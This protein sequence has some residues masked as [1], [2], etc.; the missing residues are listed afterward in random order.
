MDKIMIIFQ[1]PDDIKKLLVNGKITVSVYGMGRIGLAIAATWIRAGAKVIGVDILPEKIN[2]LNSGKISYPE[3]KTV[4]EVLNKASKNGRLIGLLDGVKAS[5]L[6][7]VKIVIVPTYASDKG[8]DLKALRDSLLSIGRGLKRGDLVIIESTVPPG[9]TKNFALPIL[10]KESKLK[11]EEDFGLAYSPERVMVGR[12][13]KD[14][15]ESYPK[16]VAGIGERSG[17]A[18]EALYSVIARKGVIRLSSTTA[19]E[20]SKVFEGIYRDLNI[21][22]ANELA[23]LCKALGIDFMEVRKASNS[24]PYCHLHVPG[25]GVGGL[26]IPVYPYFA[27]NVGR[28]KNVNLNLVSMARKINE[29]M[30]NYAIT[31]ALNALKELPLKKVKV[32]VLGLAFRG[33]IAD[34]RLSPSYS[35]VEKLL[36]LSFEV[37]VHDPLILKDETL[38]KLGVALVSDF[39]EAVKGR[40]LIFLAT[41]HSYY[42]REGVTQIA[43]LASKPLVFI[44]GRNLFVEDSIPKGVYYISISGRVVKNV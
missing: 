5:K 34:A 26:C 15:E 9:T 13:L 24:Q 28:Q 25:I 35:L 16:I 44:D 2:A 32:A 22:L 41:D 37:I 38:E 3:E 21:A 36:E 14:I 39:N 4:E 11:V 40:N 19:A 23:K 31:L 7:D 43:N 27:I 10:E 12:A 18:V 6:S 8:I 1:R 33:D 20:A 30:P 29:D 17:R 42:R